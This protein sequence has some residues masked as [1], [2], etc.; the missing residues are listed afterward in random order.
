MCGLSMNALAD[1]RFFAGASWRPLVLGALGA[2]WRHCTGTSGRP[3]VC[4][5]VELRHPPCVQ[6]RSVLF[7]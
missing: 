3:S 6:I 2:E 1:C 5:Q 7:L 4:R